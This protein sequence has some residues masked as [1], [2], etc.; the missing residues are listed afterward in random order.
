MSY[1]GNIHKQ[2]L[3]HLHGLLGEIADYEAREG[4]SPRSREYLESGTAPSSIHKSKADHKKAIFELV[5]GITSEIE[6]PGSVD[7]GYEDMFREVVYEAIGKQEMDTSISFDSVR[8]NRLQA[9]Y[10]DE[11]DMPVE[12]QSGIENDEFVIT[13]D[14]IIEWTTSIKEGLEH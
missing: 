8:L 4:R 14:K 12:Y 13:D 5:R 2:D 6:Q 1:Q 3:I 11:S 10:L 7:Q 9:K